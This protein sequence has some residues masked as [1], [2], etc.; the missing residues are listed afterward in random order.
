M[1]TAAMYIPVL[2]SAWRT[3]ATSPETTNAMPGGEGERG[4]RPLARVVIA[5]RDKSDRD[6]RLDDEQRE[7]ERE[8]Q[9]AQARRA[10]T[11][12]A[13]SSSLRRKPRAQDVSTWS[14]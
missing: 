6:G 2:F 5:R 13:D 8:R 14:P 11:A 12:S 3:R 7:P 1:P 9:P 10:A 4:V